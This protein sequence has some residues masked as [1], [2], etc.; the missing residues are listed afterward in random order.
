MIIGDPY[1]F[2]FLVDLVPYWNKKYNTKNGIFFF[3]VKGQLFPKEID[4][5]VLDTDIYYFFEYRPS[6]LVTLPVNV[7]LFNM[8]KIA[9]FKQ[10][11]NI[12]Y[13]GILDL[14][15][16]KKNKVIHGSYKCSTPTME[17]NHYYFYAVNNGSKVRILG[18]EIIRKNIKNEVVYDIS[19]EVF[20]LILPM[21]Y[22]IDVVSKLK[23]FYDN[24]IR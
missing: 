1:E 15:D 2:A 3:C 11:H 21:E 8:D 17:D 13:P 7:C 18:A 22:I 24:N 14:S 16:V 23:V 20:E 19:D 5:A 6:S 10:M 9:A 4:T 12:S